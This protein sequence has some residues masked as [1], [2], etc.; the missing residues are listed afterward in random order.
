MVSIFPPPSMFITHSPFTSP[1]YKSNNFNLTC[2]STF[3]S[4]VNTIVSTTVVWFG[5]QGNT[6][7]VETQHMITYVTSNGT[8]EF[9]SMLVFLPIDNGDHN[10]NF[11]DTGT[12]IS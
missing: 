1:I 2:I 7:P 3:S 8:K 5:P 10:S 11:N 12:Y 9:E 6:N 4:V